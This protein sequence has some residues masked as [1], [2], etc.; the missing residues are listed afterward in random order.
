MNLFVTAIRAGCV[1]KKRSNAH[2][3]VAFELT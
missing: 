2:D 3:A 1:T